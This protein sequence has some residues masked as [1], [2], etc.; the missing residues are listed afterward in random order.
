MAIGLAAGA[1]AALGVAAEQARLCQLSDAERG[2]VAAI[3]G[4]ET[5]QLA[6]GSVVRLIGAK[7]PSA[8][9][10]FN[11]DTPWPM[12]EEAKE[13]LRRLASGAEVELHFGGRREDRHGHLLAQIFVVKGDQRLWLQQELVAQGFARVY[14]FPD[15]RACV[16]ELLAAERS[17]RDEHKGLWAVFAYRIRD[18]NGRDPEDI[19]RLRQ[20]YQLV[21]GV[22]AAVGGGAGRLYLNFGRD[23]H[24]DFTV[25][26]ERK[27]KDAFV[28]AGL[29]PDALAG[30]RIRVR[31][32]IEWRNG[33]MIRASHP[34]QIEILLAQAAPHAPKRAPPKGSVA[35]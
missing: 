29:D 31:G 20:S 17:A 5:L 2:T 21:E 9:L 19:A 6:D 15:N 8:P 34:E 13:A 28:R 27:D 33:P 25:E 30:K 35:L 7:A 23:W 10:G 22:V 24:T 26:I 12:V 4:G 32:W 1:P 18:A 14:S 16:A 3:I 11:G